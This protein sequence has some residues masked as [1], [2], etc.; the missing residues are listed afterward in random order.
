M[1][2]NFVSRGRTQAATSTQSVLLQIRDPFA[3][4]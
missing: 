1:S 4:S 2:F 3:A